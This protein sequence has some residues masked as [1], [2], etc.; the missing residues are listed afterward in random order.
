MGKKIIMKN[1]E[2]KP[3]MHYSAL[4]MLGKCGEMYRRRYVE[5]EKI[6]PA[7]AMLVGTGTH[8]AAEK[9]LKNKCQTG[10]LLCSEEIG[11]IAKDT[12]TGAW[13]QGVSF[14][15]DEQK[16]GLKKIKGLTIDKTVSFARKYHSFLAPT[17][18]PIS[19]AH[20]E[21]NFVIEIP[22]YPVNISGTIDVEEENETRD[23][24][25]KGKSPSQGEADDSDQLTTYAMSR[26]VETGKIPDRLTLDCIVGLKA[27]P[28]IKSVSTTRTKDNF[29]V[30][31]RRLETAILV[32]EKGAFVPTNQDNWICSEK[33]C[34]Y[35]TTC[36]YFRGKKQF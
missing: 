21:K 24:K 22:G 20:I 28:V 6:S 12:I 5:N 9:D 2:E 19:E 10:N 32:I 26:F 18:N 36:P 30:L 29:S 4:A 3:Q 34:G 14:T 31:L 8:K 35:A 11:E 15:V 7:V 25:T 33:F 23:L 1:K 13:D 17:L 16:E 27:G